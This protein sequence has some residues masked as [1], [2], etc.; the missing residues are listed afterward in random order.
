M[1]FWQDEYDVQRMNAHLAMG[2]NGTRAHGIIAFLIK[3][4]L[5][6]ANSND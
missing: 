4:P 3:K 2:R 5:M 1:G 6:D